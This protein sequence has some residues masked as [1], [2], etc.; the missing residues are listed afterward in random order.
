[1]KSK[2]II[3]FVFVVFALAFTVFATIDWDN[4]P[5]GKIVNGKYY[6]CGDKEDSREEAKASAK[7]QADLV[8]KQECIADGFTGGYATDCEVEKSRGTGQGKHQAVIKCEDCRC[9]NLMD[10]TPFNSDSGLIGAG[11]L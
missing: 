2:P 9:T 6:G 1:M 7:V 8:C 3:A 4:C 5:T 11:P 10:I